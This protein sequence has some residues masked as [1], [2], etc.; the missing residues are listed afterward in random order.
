[1]CYDPVIKKNQ[2]GVGTQIK[3]S[4]DLQ[5]VHRACQRLGHRLLNSSIGIHQPTT[6]DCLV[7]KIRV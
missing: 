3:E 6:L 1:M 7:C 4:M 2:L 5:H